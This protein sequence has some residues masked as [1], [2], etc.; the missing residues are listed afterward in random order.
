MNTINNPEVKSSSNPAGGSVSGAGSTFGACGTVALSYMMLEKLR[1]L[2]A[3]IAAILNTGYAANLEGQAKAGVAS[4]LATNASITADGIKQIVEGAESLVAAG[5]SLCLV[6][7]SGQTNEEEAAESKKLETQVKELKGVQSKISQMKAHLNGDKEIVLTKKTSA[8]V[9]QARKAQLRAAVNPADKESPGTIAIDREALS[10]K[11]QEHFDATDEALNQLCLPPPV[12]DG[13]APIAAE[14]DKETLNKLSSKCNKELSAALKK[15]KAL[16]ETIQT[17]TNEL[18]MK[19][20]IVNQ[21]TRAVTLGTGAGFTMLQKAKNE[22]I[23]SV[24]Q[25]T[26]QIEGQI[27][28]AY[29]TG[30]Q[31]EWQDMEALNQ[32]LIALNQSQNTRG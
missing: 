24:T 5:V 25:T 10:E 32:T 4:A 31:Q 15:Q 19:T 28:N 8:E 22:E 14:W 11:A 16:H 26:S 9:L 29:M 12:E 23:R 17:R 7:K 13:Q 6:V 2:Y 1:E 27:S 20:D 18:K 3:K 30:L 21:L